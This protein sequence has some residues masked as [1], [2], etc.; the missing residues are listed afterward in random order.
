M[1]RH[2]FRSLVSNGKGMSRAL[3]RPLSKLA[4]AT[5][6][7]RVMDDDYEPRHIG[8]QAGEISAMLAECGAKSMTQLMDETIP[9]N[10]RRGRELNLP[11]AL[12]ES[13]ALASFRQIMDQNK[14]FRS[15]LGQGY[16]PTLTPSVILRC[17]LENPSWY[18]PYTPYQPEISQGRLEMLLNYQTM[19]CELTGMEISN[20]SLL[21]EGLAAAEA[22]IM[23][24]NVYKGKRKRFLISSDCYPQTISVCTTRLPPLGL[25]V[26]VVDDISAAGLDDSVCGI[27]VQ[28]SGDS[29]EVTDFTNLCQE[30]H[31]V[32]G[33]VVIASDLLA[34]T[35]LKPPGAMG[36]DIVVGVNQRFGVPMGFGGPHAGFLATKHEHQRRLPGRLI[37][38][39]KDKRG[40]PAYRLALQTREQHIRRD[41]ATSN[42]CT[43]QA[44]LANISAAYSIYHGPNGLTKI[45]ERVHQRALTFAEGCRNVGLQV[46]HDNFF[47]TVRVK[48][49][50][51]AHIVNR[52]ESHGINVR[53]FGDSICVSFDE[54]STQ[55]HVQELCEIFA[56]ASGKTMKELPSYL[57]SPIEHLKRSDPC[58]KHDIFKLHHSETAMM[59]YLYQLEKRDLGLNTAAIP[60]GSCTMKLNAASCMIPVTWPT[61]GG[62]HPF[63]PADQ[64]RGYD[65]L[66]SEAE[67]HLAEITGFHSISLQPNSGSQGEYAG[68]MCIAA[69]HRSKGE[70]HR[71]ICLIPSNAHGTNPASAAFAGMKV[72][73]VKC[74]AEGDIDMKD[75]KEKAEKNKDNLSCM[76]VTY[77]STHGVF[78]EEIKVATELIHDLG[79]QVY[80]D[81]ANLQAQV[82]YCTPDSL[83]ADVCH[84]NLHKTF[85]IPHGGG[86]PGLGPIGVR[87]HLSKFL[88]NHPIVSGVGG[89]ESFGSVSA[90]PWSSASILTISYMYMR[91]MGPDGLKRATETSILSA[92]Y[93]LAR[94]KPF[95][96]ILFTGSQGRCAHE[97]IIDLRPFKSCGITEEDVA[98]RLM[99]FNLH[100]PTMSWPVSGTL[101]IEPTESEPKYELDRMCEAFIKIRSEIQD[102]VDQ[103]HTAA[104]S[105]LRNAP[106]TADVVSSPVW[107]RPY[108]RHEGAFPLPGLVDNKF[109][110][111]VG[112]VD[113][114]YGDKNLVCSCPALSDYE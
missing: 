46:C 17:M 43:A 78:E 59:R 13:E 42:I 61:V 95:Y 99:D 2:Y 24:Y 48:V 105:P 96:D 93:M 83:G 11:E 98:K 31:D 77:P 28:H 23:T 53:T 114:S 39:S 65:Q 33:K 40:K 7:R 72:V 110:P 90:A 30:V 92:N 94:L 49:P 97:F 76:M 87:E 20:A 26:E 102:V 1:I 25:E 3:R 82:G 106:H 63:V 9:H 109:W 112:R 44:L 74:T 22:G 37:G 8:P 54:T 68:V 12:G 27:L 101:M 100:A 104:E 89:S 84:L 107:V 50:S 79:G 4:S 14:I 52:A 56:S 38:V 80:M 18:T 45:G 6:E 64:R 91:M 113:N 71:N 108:T 15:H 19:V 66:I 21:D 34:C 10:L 73:V 69:Y 103:K 75:L 67:D 86:G 111:Y 81:G 88:P 57:S 41:K 70:G 16:F 55:E 51:T 62:I 35:I 5:V 29:G 47:D 58:L 32:G 60:L 36:A 85:C